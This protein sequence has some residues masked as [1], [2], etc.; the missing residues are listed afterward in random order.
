RH[1]AP[2]RSRRERIRASHEAWCSQLPELVKA[3]MAWKHGAAEES[4][5]SSS[6]EGGAEFTVCAVYTHAWNPSLKI[7][8]QKDELANVALIQRGLLGCSPVSPEYAISLQT[9]ELYHRLRRHHA[10]L[11]FQALTRTLCDLNGV[12][13]S[14]A[15]R[16]HLS[17]AFDAY[18][19]I[20][21]YVQGQVDIVLGPTGTEW[22]MRNTCPCCTARVEGEP[23]LSPARLFA[24]DGNNSAKRI[25]SA[26]SADERVFQSSYVLSRTEVDRFK[27]EVK[28]RTPSKTTKTTDTHDAR[29]T[30]A[31]SDEDDAPWISE[32]APGD[33]PDGQTSPSSCTKNWKA[34]A[35]EN[36]Q[37]ALKIY[38]T[39]GMFVAACRH[40][41]IQKLC[42][43][44]NSGELYV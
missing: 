20:L 1:R 5:P 6:E 38:E 21:R 33:A 39:T 36:N 31:S 12:N 27:D 16:D 24:M 30:D 23:E 3:Y 2:K 35:E 7:H 17:T 34:S 41:L 9:L 18:L 32:D 10:Q 4:R 44:V 43:M 42:E 19:S 22:R 13:Y 8:Q 28:R 11:G 26:G 25:A 29:D 14:S 37:R 40:G 15:A